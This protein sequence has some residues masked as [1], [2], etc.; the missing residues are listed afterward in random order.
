MV[1]SFARP[2]V[3]ELG[4]SA[5][6]QLPKHAM[7]LGRKVFG[8]GFD[9]NLNRRFFETVSEPT[10]TTFSRTIDFD[11]PSR[12]GFDKLINLMDTDEE[13]AAK[14]LYILEETFRNEDEI[15]RNLNATQ[16]KIAKQQRK[17]WRAGEKKIGRAPTASGSQGRSDIGYVSQI[18][19]QAKPDDTFGLSMQGV[20]KQADA[21]DYGTTSIYT[22]TGEANPRGGGAITEVHHG[23][24]LDK[25]MRLV[26]GH[27][28]WQQ[29]TPDTPSPL[30][31]MGEKLFGVKIGNNPQ[32][33]VDILGWLNTRGRASRVRALN[34]QVGDVMHQKTIDDLLGTS[35]YQPRELSGAETIEFEELRNRGLVETV[36]D[37]MTNYKSIETGRAFGQGNVGSEIDIYRP[38]AILSG[39]QKEAPLET[40]KLTAETYPQRVQLAFDALKR[41]GVPGVDEARGRWDMKLAKISRYDDI[42]GMDHSHVHR[43]LEQVEKTKGTAL[44]ELAQMSDEEIFNLSTEEAFGLYIRQMQEAETVLANVLQYRYGMIEKIFKDMQTKNPEFPQ[45]SFDKLP[46]EMKQRFF[47]QNVNTIAVKGNV[48]KDISMKKAMK[49]V[50]NWNNHIADTFGWSP[51]S[52]WIT[53]KEI[54]EITKELMEKVQ[55]TQPIPGV[56]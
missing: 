49:P 8:Q 36:D 13:S 1:S 29:V 53:P 5:L 47:K 14:A 19:R 41:H 46:A 11:P 21:A 4:E 15:V 42:L 16:R 44:Y 23:G 18:G 55:T 6:R 2:F 27:N 25:L 20:S 39:T 54:E 7:D 32:T 37:Y 43:I 34:E 38:G 28:T 35:D 50:K 56:V 10:A 26:F 3:A 48:M 31:E 52:L 40:I 9:P 33:T 30:V 51:Q 17:N 45:V 12:E 24:P 22:E